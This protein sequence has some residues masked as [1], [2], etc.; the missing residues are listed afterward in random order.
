[1][2]N[3]IRPVRAVAGALLLALAATASAADAP[4]A[5][6]NPLFRDRFTAD[7]APLVVGDR[8]Y[9]YVGHDEARGEEMFNM[10][11]WRVYSTTDMKQWT[12]HG[13]I[14]RATDFKWAKA[15]AWASQV[16]EKDGRFWF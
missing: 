16:I 12:D 11:E 8:L 7:P 3:R 14:M 9:L 6:S 2:P 13:P 1:M 10:R 4:A 5:G 15:D